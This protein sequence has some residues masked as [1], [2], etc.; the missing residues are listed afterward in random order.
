MTKICWQEPLTAKWARSGDAGRWYV[1]QLKSAFIWGIAAVSAGLIF[2]YAAAL[3]SRPT[4]KYPIA[5]LVFVGCASALFFGYLKPLLIW[6]VEPSI[7]ISP[8]GI[9][10]NQYNGMFPM[11]R[12][13]FW[14]WNSIGHLAVENC[15]HNDKSVDVLV[16]FDHQRNR[17]TSIGIRPDV[18]LTA[19]EEIAVAHGVSIDR[20]NCTRGTFGT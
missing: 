5:F 10:R 3:F 12:I 15:V 20:G 16:L 13:E 2:E 18:S 9:N 17:I 14:G 4:A 8:K 19:V 7:V 11:L 1:N 6:F